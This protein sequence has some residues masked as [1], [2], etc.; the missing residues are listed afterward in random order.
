M[1]SRNNGA[2]ADMDFCDDSVLDAI[3]KKRMK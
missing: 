1:I 2:M 3:G